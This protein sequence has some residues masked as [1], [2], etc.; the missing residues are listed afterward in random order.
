MEAYIAGLADADWSVM[1]STASVDAPTSVS[2]FDLLVLGSPT[3]AWK[4]AGPITRYLGRLGELS[5]LS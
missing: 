2:D 1:V 5:G 3:Y 4:P